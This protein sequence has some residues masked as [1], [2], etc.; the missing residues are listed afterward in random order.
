M[1]RL[2]SKFTWKTC[3]VGVVFVLLATLSACG[4]AASTGASADGGDQGVARGLPAVET[5]NTN[6]YGVVYPTTDIG[7]GV[8]QRIK[9][10]RFL[11][12]PAGDA[13]ALKTVTLSD[14]YDPEQKHPE[15]AI[16]LIHIQAAGYWC[17][18]C[19]KETQEFTPL[20]EELRGK[21]I[22][23]VTTVAEGKTPG[24]EST[25]DDLNKWF[26]KH[27]PRNPTVIDPGNANL[28]VFYTAAALPWNAWIDAR[29]MEI[30]RYDQGYEA[31]RADAESAL[32][33]WARR[34]PKP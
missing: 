15:G 24:A 32:A 8:N 12:Y 27:K 28:G 2:F 17:T 33:A 30:M 25:L 10:F 21:G 18:F 31:V 14:Y 20:T 23:W 7:T 19:Q 29:S 4:T 5:R 3:A 11:G 9:N 26:G 22:V 1:I 6:A 16:K 34:T 13:S